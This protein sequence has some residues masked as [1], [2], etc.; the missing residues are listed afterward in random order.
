MLKIMN[1]I[2][3]VNTDL[4]SERCIVC[5]AHPRGGAPRLKIN[6]EALVAAYK[7]GSS[8]RYLAATYGV[9]FGTIRSRLVEA[10]VEFRPRGTRA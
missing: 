1:Y 6:T 4:K 2:N 10:G 5:G 9:S 8:I 7:Y 3:S